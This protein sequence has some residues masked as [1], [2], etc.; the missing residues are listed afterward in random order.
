MR[1]IADNLRITKTDIH[2]AFKALDPGP[3]QELQES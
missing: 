1:L 2:K 3:V